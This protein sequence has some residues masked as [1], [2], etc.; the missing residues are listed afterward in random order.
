MYRLTNENISTLGNLGYQYDAVGNRTN[1]TS[2]LGL[3]AQSLNYNKNDWLTSD[4]YDNNGNTTLSAGKPYQ[5]DYENRLTNFNNGQVIL[6]CDADGNRIKKITS[7]TTTLY[8]VD[9]RNPGGCPQ[10]LEELAVSGG[11]TNLSRAYTWGLS[12]ISQRIPGTSTTFYGFDGHGSTRFLTSTNGTVTD[13]YTYDACG[14]LISSTGNTPNNFLYCCYQNDPDIGLVYDNARYLNLNTGR[15]WT[16]DS[17]DGNNEDPLSLHK[18]LYCQADPVNGTDP[19]GKAVYVVTRPL[20][21]PGG[22]SLAPSAVHVFLAFDDSDISGIP[23]LQRWENAVRASCDPTAHN[24]SY[25]ITYSINASLVTFSFHPKSVLTGD[26]SEQY[27]GVVL[28]PGS[29]VAYSDAIDLNAFDKTGSGYKRYMVVANNEDLQLQIYNAVIKSRDKNNNGNPDL[30]P[31]Q[32]T[33]YNCGSWVDTILARNGVAFPDR[34]INQGVGL[35][36]QPT[37]TTTA[38]YILNATARVA[39]AGIQGIEDVWGDMGDI[40]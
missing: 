18:Y 35:A 22:Q 27:F 29:Y 6:V 33:V 9:A 14:N 37:A 19:S 23:N 26:E 40:W 7:T 16:R 17:Y 31:Y 28:T 24:N 21:M 36:T 11:I 39:R 8:L 12:L 32:V 25:G 15:F 13:T 1:R 30:Y 5:Y 10:V 34:T 3:S 38:G 2:G 20:N 4:T